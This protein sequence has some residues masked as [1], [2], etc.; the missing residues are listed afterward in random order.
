MCIPSARGPGHAAAAP[1]RH[2]GT[3]AAQHGPTAVALVCRVCCPERLGLT[4]AALLP[5]ALGWRLSVNGQ[6]SPYPPCPLLGLTGHLPHGNRQLLTQPNV[7]ASEGRSPSSRY[8]GDPGRGPGGPVPKR[9][10][11]RALSTAGA[12]EKSRC[13]AQPEQPHEN[14]CHQAPRLTDVHSELRIPDRRTVRKGRKQAPPWPAPGRHP[15]CTTHQLQG[16]GR[17]LPSPVLSF[18]ICKIGIGVLPPS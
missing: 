8:V 12:L 17:S 3:A 16:S 10:S 1:C 18:P 9:S 2:T 14:P 7:L 4:V 6:L 15:G 11:C 13:P 5:I